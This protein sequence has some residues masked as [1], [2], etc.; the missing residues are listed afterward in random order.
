[1]Q[2]QSIAGAEPNTEEG[3]PLFSAMLRARMIDDRLHAMGEAGEIGFL[4]R[5]LGR[6][7]AVVGTVA[8]LRDEDWIFATSRDW[9][10]AITRGM[11]LTTF[12]HRVFGDAS[13]PLR[14]RDMPGGLSAREQRVASVSAP[15][16]THL[17]HA[18][19]VAYAAR[20]RGDALVS[21]A[22]F[23]AAEV[24]AADFHT[25]LNFAGVMK[26]PVLFLCRVRAGEEGAAEH[27]V[28][29][30]LAAKRCDGSQVFDVVQTVK[31]A[32]ERASRGE[33]ATVIDLEVGGDDEAI[34]RARAHLLSAAVWSAEAESELRARTEEELARAIDA[35]SRAGAPSPTSLF[36][37]VYEALPPHL[38]SQRD[39]LSRRH[40]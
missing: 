5:G 33:G 6:E 14:G 3:A 36:D 38:I 18:V 35:A 11:S 12:A 26:V 10:A 13:D 19:G 39:E 32:R 22:L 31:A 16:G 28:A 17:P 34:E 15:A 8:A 25:A 29:Y 27:A 21:A 9:A 30:G 23:D 7:A 37:D 4:P 20:Q 2:T 1:M 40:D 24:D